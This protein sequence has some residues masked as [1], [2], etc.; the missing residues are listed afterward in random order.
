MVQWRLLWMKI[1]GIMPA[2]KENLKKIESF[3]N[4]LF[5]SKR[6][7]LAVAGCTVMVVWRN[8]KLLFNFG[9]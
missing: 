8:R 6:A 4:K 2:T 7:E 1:C 3:D 9:R 5:L